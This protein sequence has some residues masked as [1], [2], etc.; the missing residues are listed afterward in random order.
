MTDKVLCQG[1][2]FLKCSPDYWFHVGG[3]INQSRSCI[4][5]I[6]PE[7]AAYAAAWVLNLQF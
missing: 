5:A 2:K 4:A 6:R 7:I 1:R 3:Q